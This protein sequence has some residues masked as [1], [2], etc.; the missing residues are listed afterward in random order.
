MGVVRWLL[1]VGVVLIPTGVLAQDQ[2]SFTLVTTEPMKLRRIDGTPAW[3]QSCGSHCQEIYADGPISPGDD[4]RLELLIDQNKLRERTMLHINSPGG[5]V[6]AALA[7]GRLIRRHKLGISVSGKTGDECISACTLVFMG[8]LFRWHVIG[9]TYGIHRFFA[10]KGSRI[11]DPL[12][13]SQ[14]VS[15]Q[16]AAYLTEMGISG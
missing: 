5:D 7:R 10:A 6:M 3:P 16:I 14:I 1:A 13:A 11:D 8:G 4:A 9:S 2:M 12:A 15:G